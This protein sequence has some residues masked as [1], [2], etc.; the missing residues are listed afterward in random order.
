VLLLGR[1]LGAVSLD[2]GDCPAGVKVVLAQMLEKIP[3]VLLVLLVAHLP[4]DR[5][6]RIE[7]IGADVLAERQSA[8]CAHLGVNQA[9]P[10]AQVLRCFG[11]DKKAVDR[12]SGFRVRSDYQVADLRVVRGSHLVA[13]ADGVHRQPQYAM[14]GHIVHFF[15]A[16][17]DPAAVPQALSVLFNCP[18]T[19]NAPFWLVV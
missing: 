19:H 10:V 1:F 3:G 8:G 15:A 18:N 11:G 12:L 7:A 4:G 6:G 14:G 5:H 2:A 16:D 13:G 9:G 17:V